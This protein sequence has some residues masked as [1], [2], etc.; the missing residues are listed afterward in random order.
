MLVTFRKGFYAFSEGTSG[1]EGAFREGGFEPFSYMAD[2][3][4]TLICT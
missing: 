1:P 2:S 3:T 4:C